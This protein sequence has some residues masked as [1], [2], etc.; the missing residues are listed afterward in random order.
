MAEK[1]ATTLKN[2]TWI[3]LVAGFAV[4]IAVGIATS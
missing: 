2:N 1:I 4:L 3:W